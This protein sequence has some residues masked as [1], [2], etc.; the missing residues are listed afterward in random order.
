MKFS[1]GWGIAC[2]M[3]LSAAGHAQAGDVGKVLDCMRGNIPNTVRIQTVEI[4]AV[5]RSGG[6]RKL[7]GR[8]FGTRENDRVRIMLRVEAP[9]DLAGAAYLVREGETSDEMYLYV[10]ALRKVRRITGA[11]LDGQLWGT[12]LSYNDFKQVQN[13]FSGA[14]AV[15][16]PAAQYLQRPVNVVSFV[17]RKEDG[18][19]YRKIR[20]QVDQQTCVAL[21]V[22]F[23]EA[24][25][26]RKQ[27]TV[28]PSDLKKSGP[29]W[30]ASNI[31][32]RD[33]KNQ[34]RTLLQ[35]T[36]VSSGDK[37][38]SRYFNPQTFYQGN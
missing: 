1:V 38:A 19:R 7:K 17:P 10:P 14:G 2:L 36:G 15:L 31:E 32:V 30:F 8:L 20:T 26:V 25:G 13:A 33:V 21:M 27:L 11:S 35:V 16:E 9:H 22:E 29:H 34:S 23:F 24:A 5:D 4:T 18:S 37:L 3:L 6:E 12:D 28:K